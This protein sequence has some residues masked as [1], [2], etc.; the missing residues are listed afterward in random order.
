MSY[1]GFVTHSVVHELNGKILG[2]KIDK[3]YQPES[4]EIIISVRTFEWDYRFDY[5][6]PAASNARVL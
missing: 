3:I 2:G 5:Y 6:Q 1:D 4:D